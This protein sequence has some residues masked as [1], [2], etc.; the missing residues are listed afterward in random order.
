MGINKEELRVF[1]ATMWQMARGEFE[2]IYRFDLN[3]F[4]IYTQTHIHTPMNKYY[5]NNTYYIS[6]YFIFDSI[7]N[8]TFCILINNSTCSLSVQLPRTLCICVRVCVC[9]TMACQRGR[10]NENNNNC[11][12]HMPAVCCIRIS[13][14]VDS[15]KVINNAPVDVDDDDDGRGGRRRGLGMQMGLLQ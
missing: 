10:G 4:N 1:D 6:L 11:N 8:F 3:D 7:I 9:I 2:I 12:K 15:M 14:N 13:F 5:N